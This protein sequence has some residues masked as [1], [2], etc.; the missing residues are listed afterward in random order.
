MALCKLWPYTVMATPGAIDAAVV[1][2][3]LDELC[4]PGKIFLKKACMLAV[5]RN[6]LV[7]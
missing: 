2:Q 5:E 4:E 7:R 1:V 3:C 6:I